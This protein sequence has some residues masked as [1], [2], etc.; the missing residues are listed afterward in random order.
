[1]SKEIHCMCC[2]KDMHE[3]LFE[4]NGDLIHGVSICDECIE[5]TCFDSIATE[6]NET[7]KVG[8]GQR[9][10]ANLAEGLERHRKA[11]GK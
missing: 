8:K 4:V 1:M 9:G 7:R 11:V 6:F 5:E 2:K 3:C 10:A